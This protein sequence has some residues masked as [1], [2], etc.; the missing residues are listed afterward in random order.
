LFYGLN[1]PFYGL[2]IAFYG[3][4]RSGE[5]FRSY[6]IGRADGSFWVFIDQLHTFEGRYPSLLCGGLSAL[7]GFLL[8]YL[9][10]NLPIN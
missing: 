3:L 5:P 4:N 10:A 7:F 2:N 8:V 6:Y 1:T 9:I